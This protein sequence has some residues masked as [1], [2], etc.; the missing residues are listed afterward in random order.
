VFQESAA[1][2]R[3]GAKL[4]EEKG[5]SCVPANRSDFLNATISCA[6]SYYQCREPRKDAPV[7]RS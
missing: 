4:E 7:L 6:S 2:F 5:R 3:A 1:K